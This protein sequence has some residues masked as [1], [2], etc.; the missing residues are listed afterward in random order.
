MVLFCVWIEPLILSTF[1]RTF[2]LYDHPNVVVQAL[3]LIS[4]IAVVPPKKLD[5]EFTPCSR[6]NNGMMKKDKDEEE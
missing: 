1:S 2:V 3:N 5:N 4:A 6:G